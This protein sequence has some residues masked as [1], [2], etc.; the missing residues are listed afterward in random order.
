M[1]TPKAAASAQSVSSTAGTAGSWLALVAATTLGLGAETFRAEIRADGLSKTGHYRLVVQS[2]DA[3]DRA[4][5]SRRA[6]PVASLQRAVTGE[7]LRRG[8]MVNLVE[9]RD[10]RPAADGAPA[11][12][13]WVEGGD[14]DLEFDGRTA[15]P[16]RGS[17]YGVAKRDGTEDFVQIQ[18][19]RRRAA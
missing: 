3:P 13:A 17:V 1:K 11:V 5:P 15:R 2:Y 6:R 10:G 4:I 12:V 9:L 14:P 8:V 18:L 19:D 7:E 16:A